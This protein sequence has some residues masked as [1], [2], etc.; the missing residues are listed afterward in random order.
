[1]TEHLLDVRFTLCPIPVI[2]TQ[3][4]I[5][6]LQPGDRLRVVATDP[7]TLAD[8]PAWCRVHGH[9]VIGAHAEL[10]EVVIEVEVGLG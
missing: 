2:R 4:R 9:T 7:G 5:A 6:D 1:M 8:V 3:D 10:D